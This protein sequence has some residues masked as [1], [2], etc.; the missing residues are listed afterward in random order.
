MK[1][2]NNNFWSEALISEF[3][4][5]GVRKA[6][7]SPGSRNTPITLALAK[8][9]EIKKYAV[10]DERISAFFALGMA[11][12]GGQPVI[13]ECTS[14]TATAELYPAIVE[15]FFSRIPLIIL[16]ADRPPR[17]LGYGA[18]QTINQVDIF[19]N[20]TRLSIDAGLPQVTSK[21]I[22]K[23]FDIMQMVYEVLQN[24]P[25]PVHI[26][27]PFEEPLEPRS[28]TSEVSENF[29][30]S[31]KKL[32]ANNKY[33]QFK[34]KD[35]AGFSESTEF[36]EI[37]NLVINSVRGL[38]IAGPNE[39]GNP[40]CRE[41]ILELAESLD[42]PLL[43]DVASGLRFLRTQS[44][45]IIA[46]ADSLLRS[47]NINWA[48]KPDFIL[49]FGRTVTSKATLKFLST[50]RSPRYV[51]NQ[52]GDKFD[53]SQNAKAYI[54]QHPTTFIN[55][56]LA[57]LKSAG[58]LDSSLQKK[59]K[60]WLNFFKSADSKIEE[61]KRTV[62]SAT[63]FPIESRIVNEIINLAPEGCNIFLSN[64][65]P[66]RDFDY[67]ASKS[68][69]NLHIFFNRGAS[70]ID[71]IISTAFGIA[72]ASG[73]HTTVVIGDQAFQHDIGSL[74]MANNLGLS[75]TIVLVNNNSGGIFYAL[76]VSEYG[77]DFK[78]YFV[79]PQNLNFGE[80]V[81]GFS[82]YHK[83]MPSWQYFKREYL[84]SFERE[85]VKVLQFTTNA[86]ES[87]QIR[88]A[89]WEKVD[90]TLSTEITTLLTR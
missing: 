12:A 78:K 76:P 53:P 89:F 85:G 22:K 63:R 56:L 3:I 7:V 35:S 42:I 17:F 54:A 29:I 50:T 70:G 11:K 13:V 26:N 6:T 81:K 33:S 18:N 80:I 74:A 2:N 69:K 67:F 45:N 82:A 51:I 8:A 14:G 5:I 41:S 48:V 57:E 72:A 32:S 88:K 59:R 28:Y 10:V 84:T 21:G 86:D 44:S 90:S 1:I 25:G 43:A 75:I 55:A 9:E 65:T 71:G 15:A 30:A 79:L 58:P 49:Q 73:K 16:T 27:L 77:E 46:N 37:L 31:V 4:K 61:M 87:H 36:K 60:K 23:I 20:H 38:I 47:E 34:V 39:T 19:R 68:N 64:S 24:D 62:I 52:F 66:V 40:D 83:L